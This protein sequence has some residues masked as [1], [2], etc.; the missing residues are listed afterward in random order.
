MQMVTS[1]VG[2]A[3][4]GHIVVGTFDGRAWKSLYVAPEALSFVDAIDAK[5]VWVVGTRR[6]FI[7]SD[8]GDRWRT[9]TGAGTPIPLSRVH[10]T[11]ADD[12]WGVG[13]NAL[14]RGTKGGDLW[15]KVPSTPCPVQQACSND[16][17]HGWLATNKAVYNTIDGGVHWSRRLE[18]SDPDFSH[19]SALD[20]QCTPANAAWVLFDSNN[21]GLG[22]DGYAGYRCPSD[23]A[24]QVVVQNFLTDAPP[25]TSGPGSTPGPFSVI[26]DHTAVFVGFTAPVQDP[27]TMMLLGDDGRARGPAL[28]VPD[29]GPR[30]PTPSSVS[31]TSRDRGWILDDVGD[32]AHILATNDGGKTWTVQYRV[33]VP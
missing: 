30:E 28:V 12:G 14:F 23:A 21:H 3:V 10:F 19:A 5:H 31:F 32:E 27:M 13:Q 26:D 17:Q 15:T 29:R 16:G 11:S 7:T 8:G 9:T 24:C 2:Y 1:T 6:V 4:I 18:V 33:T 25:D 20:V 22:S